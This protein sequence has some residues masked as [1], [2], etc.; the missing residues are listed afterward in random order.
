[1]SKQFKQTC[2]DCKHETPYVT[3]RGGVQCCLE[4]GSDNVVNSESRIQA[5]DYSHHKAAKVTKL[6]KGI[7]RVEIKVSDFKAGKFD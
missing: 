7:S 1:M 3:R 6:G 4:C 5:K 2:L